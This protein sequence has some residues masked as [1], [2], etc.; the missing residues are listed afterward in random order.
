MRSNTFRCN[1][2]TLS[3]YVHFGIAHSSYRC[4][5]EI[6]ATPGVTPG[7]GLQSPDTATTVRVKDGK[8][9][10]TDGPFVDRKEALNGFLIFETDDLDIRGK[11]CGTSRSAATHLA[12]TMIH[13]HVVVSGR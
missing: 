7:E 5:Q 9:I 1:E 2:Y 8:T 4:H 12:V 13:E 11:S 3:D 6:N 10:T